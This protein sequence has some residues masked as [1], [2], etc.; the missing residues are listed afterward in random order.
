MRWNRILKAF[1]NGLDPDETPHNVALKE[2]NRTIKGIRLQDEQRGLHIWRW[3]Y[4]KP[5]IREADNDNE[6]GLV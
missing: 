2:S 1:A 4:V 6:R 5:R 3:T